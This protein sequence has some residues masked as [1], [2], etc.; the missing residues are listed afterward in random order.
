M[1][2]P[3]VPPPWLVAARVPGLLLRLRGL[4]FRE[5]SRPGRAGGLD[6]IDVCWSVAAG[7]SLVDP[8]RGLTYQTRSLLLALRAGEPL[9]IAGPW[10]GRRSIGPPGRLAR[11]R[12]ARLISTSEA[13]A[14]RAGNPHALGL[15][16]LSRASAYLEGHFEGLGRLDEAEAILREQCTG[17]I[18][19]LDTWPFGLW[20]FISLGEIGEL[21]RHRAI[22]LRQARER[23]DLFAEINFSPT[24]W[25]SRSWAR[26]APGSG[27]ARPR[28]GRSGRPPDSSSSITT[29]CSPSATSTSTTATGLRP[30]RSST[31]DG[32][33]TGNRCS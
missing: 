13:L 8:I 17:V 16:R 15:A 20:A 1:P 32:P 5:R 3:V 22:K 9:R 12:T 33:A 6:L 19:E 11:R 27:R 24:S 28:Q 26:T 14:A 10:P 31:I 23:G 18:W 4:G 25:P 29:W 30:G 7:L 2:L 21:A